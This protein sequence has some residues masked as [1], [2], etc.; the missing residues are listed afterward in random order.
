MKR[1][2]TDS[3]QGDGEYKTEVLL[4]AKLQHRNLVKL[5]GFCLEE[6]ER[7]LIYE[8]VP[9][10]SLDHFLFGMMITH[11]CYSMTFDINSQVQCAFCMTNCKMVNCIYTPRVSISCRCK[12]AI[13]SELGN[14]L[15][16]HNRHSS[17]TAISS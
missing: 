4:V 10:A 12:Q 3:G 14:T 5:L 16:D 8:F 9:N 15:Q 11:Y 7:I 1:L 17:W 2:S 6:K 13:I